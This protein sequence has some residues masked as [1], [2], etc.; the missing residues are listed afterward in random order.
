[1]RF[2]YCMRSKNLNF[3][4]AIIAAWICGSESKFEKKN[5]LSVHKS[6]ANLYSIR[7]SILRVHKSTANLH[8]MRLSNQKFTANLYCICLSEHKTCA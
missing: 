5:V 4:R 2:M 6:T 3:L 1:M 8:C 7:L